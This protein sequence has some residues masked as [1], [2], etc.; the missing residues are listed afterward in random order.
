VAGSLLLFGVSAELGRDL[1]YW[2]GLLGVVI[3]V[4]M[5]ISPSGLLSLPS[6]IRR[7]RAL[8]GGR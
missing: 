7:W 2:R 1:T 6:L 4:V 8:G 5:V 3:M